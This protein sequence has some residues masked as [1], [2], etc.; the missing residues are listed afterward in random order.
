MHIIVRANASEIITYTPRTHIIDR[1]M[2]SEMLLDMLQKLNLSESDASQPSR[3]KGPNISPSEIQSY[4]TNMAAA[5]TAA[6]HSGTKAEKGDLCYVFH[7]D[8][9]LGIAVQT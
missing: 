2:A 7:V 3:G 1:A 9:F 6:A 8:V 4:F 5:A